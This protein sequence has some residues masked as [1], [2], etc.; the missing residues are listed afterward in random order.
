MVKTHGIH[1]YICKYREYSIQALTVSRNR[2]WSYV[3]TSL[4][5][6]P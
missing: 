5:I 4:I 6:Y 3:G 1:M 2:V